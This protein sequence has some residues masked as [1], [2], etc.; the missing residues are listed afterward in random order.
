MGSLERSAR[1][2]DRFEIQVYDGRANA[3]GV[4]SLE[5]H[6][7]FTDRAREQS[8][9]EHQLHLTFEGALGVS[10]IFEP[11]VYFQTAL[12]PDGTVNYAGTKLRAK[13]VALPLLEGHLR[14]GANFELA[15]VP[16]RFES[17]RWGVEVRPIV[18]VDLDRL[19]ISA[20]PIV[21][22]PLSG[23]VRDGPGFEPAVSAS[24]GLSARARAGLE[25]YTDVG[26][27][28][29]STHERIQYLF[30]ATDCEIAPRLD[31]NAGVGWGLTEESEPLTFKAILG[32]ELD[33]IF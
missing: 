15:N 19:T 20:N 12:L 4:P 33:P 16:R 1:A 25:Y 23:A 13:F 5:T 22:V 31:L 3:P 7:N 26:Q 6:V 27:L 14:L 29:A 24:F 21:G 18:S 2:L 30:L 17:E 11:G 8:D 10:K 32:W 9:A 28:A